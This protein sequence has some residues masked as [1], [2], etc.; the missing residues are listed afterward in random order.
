MLFD[1]PGVIIHTNL[2]RAPLVKILW[3]LW[4]RRPVAILTW[5]CHRLVIQIDYHEVLR[6]EGNLALHQSSEKLG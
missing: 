6:V 1:Q 3:R 5:I 2:G 4:R